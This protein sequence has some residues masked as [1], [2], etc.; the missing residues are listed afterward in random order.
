[1]P[2][3]WGG[4]WVFTRFRVSRHAALPAVCNFAILNRLYAAADR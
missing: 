1:M 4:E 3:E 2:I